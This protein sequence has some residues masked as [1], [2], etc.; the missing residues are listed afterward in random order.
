MVARPRI[1]SVP[2]LGARRWFAPAIVKDSISSGSWEILSLVKSAILALA[3]CGCV[4]KA[5][6]GIGSLKLGVRFHIARAKN[7]TWNRTRDKSRVSNDSDISFHL[8]VDSL[9]KGV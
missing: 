5:I 9:P 3:Y 6:R 2:N 4:M 7:L 1:A 8:S